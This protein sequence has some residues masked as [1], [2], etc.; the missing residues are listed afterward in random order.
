MG[1]AERRLSRRQRLGGG[2]FLVVLHDTSQKRDFRL[3]YGNVVASV[4]RHSRI[5][6]QEIENLHQF[7]K[8]VVGNI[9]PL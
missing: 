6:T 7:L 2:L 5:P 3:R 8:T 9:E 4:I 1:P